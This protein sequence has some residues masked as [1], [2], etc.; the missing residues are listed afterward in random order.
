MAIFLLKIKEMYTVLECE[1]QRI[2]PV[3]KYF[4][5]VLYNQRNILQHYICNAIS[6]Y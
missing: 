1:K 2:T 5:K 4:I 6:C 3:K